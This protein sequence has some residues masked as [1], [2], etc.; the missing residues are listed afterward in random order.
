MAQPAVRLGGPAGQSETEVLAA[1]TAMERH[2]KLIA[3]GRRSRR[4]DS[5][6]VSEEPGKTERRGGRELLA[7]M[8]QAALS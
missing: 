4:E 1:K 5:V 7:G 3:G 6:C 8:K 2:Q